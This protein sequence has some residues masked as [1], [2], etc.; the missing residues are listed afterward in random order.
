MSEK[1]TEGKRADKISKRVKSQV[2]PPK[3]SGSEDNLK[4]EIGKLTN[5]I[6][7]IKLI[8]II[9]LGIMTFL[10]ITTFITNFKSEIRKME[11]VGS[12]GEMG[13]FHPKNDMQS[14]R[15]LT[16]S[17][18]YQKRGYGL[19]DPNDDGIYKTPEMIPDMNQFK[20]D[21]EIGENCFPIKNSDRIFICLA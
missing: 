3:K 17:E 2:Y 9:M 10:L 15:T 13:I 18:D 20:P 14:D 6:K 8:L 7:D 4:N 11:R 1:E 12:R 21:Y 19:I 16:D 5:V